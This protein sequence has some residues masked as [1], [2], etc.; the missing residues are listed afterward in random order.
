MNTQDKTLVFRHT[1][2]EAL[3]EHLRKKRP[4]DSL[5]LGRSRVVKL[6]RE[7]S[8]PRLSMRRSGRVVSSL[9]LNSSSQIDQSSK[10]PGPAVQSLLQP[11]AACRIVR[12][13]P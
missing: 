3:A 2:A 6:Q 9:R 10:N 5:R 11:F 4:R 7:E 13:H 1:F 12:Q 8:D